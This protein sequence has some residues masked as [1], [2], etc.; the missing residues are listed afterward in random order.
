[1]APEKKN[2]EW[3]EKDPQQKGHDYATRAEEAGCDKKNSEEERGEG[4]EGSCH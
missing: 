3:I 1:M 2:K 4:Q